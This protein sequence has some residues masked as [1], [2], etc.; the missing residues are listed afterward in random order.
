MID[1]QDSNARARIPSVD[2]L[3][4][5]ALFQHLLN[6][7]GRAQL[8]ESIRRVLSDI[9]A[10]LGNGETIPEPGE[11]QERVEADLTSRHNDKLKRV[12]NLTGT[13]LH[14]NLGRAILPETAIEAIVATAGSATNLE[15]D[16][17]TGERGDRDSITEDLLREI[18][19]AEAATLVN[20]NAAAV[21]LVL[22]TLA[23]DGQVPVSRGELVEIGGS[24]RIP[25]IMS[26]AGCKLVEIGTTNRT[27]ARDYRNAITPATALLMRVHTSNYRVEG[28]TQTVSDKEVAAIA[29]ENGLPFATDLGSGTL[30]DLR[31]W[32]LPREPTVT[33]TLSNGADL[34]T[35]SG[36]KLLGGPQAGIIVGREELVRQIKANPLKRALRVDKMTIAAIHAVLKLYLDPDNLA[37]SL[38]SFRLLTRKIEEIIQVSTNIIPALEEIFTGRAEVSL[39][40]CTSQIGSGSLPLDLLPSKAISIRPV[41]RSKDGEQLS[42]ISHQLRQLPVPVI[43]RI[44]NGAIMLDLRCL[45]DE[46]TFISQLHLLK[47]E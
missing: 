36:D 20:N 40:D 33:E 27:H 42:R 46:A 25:D 29:H 14:T 7:F 4:G 28:F 31:A 8:T 35:F 43:G 19:G 38:P 37:R 47:A 39:V 23:L 41:N 16:L 6:R 5:A 32:G 12:F 10:D 44:K 45:E 15:Y 34:V 21:L 22:N 2:K 13:V 11:I 1:K 30:V 26:R 3:L 18:T 24:F 9:R 17:T